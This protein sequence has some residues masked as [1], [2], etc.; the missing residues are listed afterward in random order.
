MGMMDKIMEFMMEKMSKEE[1]EEIIGRMIDQFFADM[2]VEDKGKMM[3]KVMSKMMEGINMTEIIS[4]IMST[5][6]ESSITSKMVE[7]DQKVKIP[8]MLQMMMEIMPHCLKTFLPQISQNKRI[9]F[10]LKMITI[11]V[12]QGCIGM[13]EEEKR[14]FVVKVVEKIKAL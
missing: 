4:K 8:I 14:D 12:E 10:I 9:D 3:A 1:K 2:T 13:S 5:M 7:N 6:A 11:L